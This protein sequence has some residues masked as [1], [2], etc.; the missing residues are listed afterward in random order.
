[1]RAT[2]GYRVHLHNGWLIDLAAEGIGRWALRTRLSC[3]VL[4]PYR[5]ALQ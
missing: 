4:G 5:V 1:M 3:G 2:S